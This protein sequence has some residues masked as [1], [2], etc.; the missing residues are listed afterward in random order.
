MASAQM[1]AAAAHQHAS[2]ATQPSAAA[3]IA[4][5]MPDDP[6]LNPT[7]S[8]ELLPLEL[9]P[10]ASTADR[11]RPRFRDAGGLTGQPRATL[12]PVAAEYGRETFAQRLGEYSFKTLLTQPEVVAALV[13]IRVECA[14]VR[15]AVLPRHGESKS[16]AP[17]GFRQPKSTAKQAP[18]NP[19]TN[20]SVRCQSS[21]AKPQRRSAWRS[22]SSRRARPRTPPPTT[23][24]TTGWPR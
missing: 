14:K 11:W 8:A 15:G 16:E 2:A 23:C 20:R 4:P 22:L 19:L 13:K 5:V 10:G 24:G 18:L 17:Y 6:G 21:A 12:V 7:A 9:P 1:T 3:S